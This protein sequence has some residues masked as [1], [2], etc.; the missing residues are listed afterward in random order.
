MVRRASAASRACRVTWDSF[1]FVAA[2]FHIQIQCGR[3]RRRT[4]RGY[5]DTSRL[6]FGASQT[7]ARRARRRRSCECSLDSP[8]S[9]FDAA[10]VEPANLVRREEV[11]AEFV[12]VA[13]IPRALPIPALGILRPVQH[14]QVLPK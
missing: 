4:R 10:H 1:V 8:G 5:I 7:L 11:L 12:S 2:S 14:A 9:G 13:G 6:S 3:S